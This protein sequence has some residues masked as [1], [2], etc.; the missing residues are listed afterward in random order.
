MRL[1]LWRLAAQGVPAQAPEDQIISH[2][3]TFPSAD[4]AERVKTEV[5][6]PVRYREPGSQE[7]RDDEFSV[8]KWTLVEPFSYDA[9]G[10]GQVELRQLLDGSFRILQGWSAESR[11]RDGVEALRA[12]N[13]YWPDGRHLDEA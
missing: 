11:A 1:S 4:W 12:H 5:I 10:I 6:E 8:S 2:T 13:R 3:I 9:K 7:V